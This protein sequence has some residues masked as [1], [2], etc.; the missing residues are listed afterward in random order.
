[1]KYNTPE[2]CG[3]PTEAIK[4]YIDHL[5]GK[6][7]S[8]HS[9]IICR[10]DD[11]VFEKYWAPFTRDFK[12]RMYSVTKSFVAFAIGF[13]LD[14]GR[15]SLDDP[16]SKYFPKECALVSDDRIKE[17]SIRNMLMMCTAYPKNGHFWFNTRTDDR[18]L[19]Y[20]TNNDGA[21]Y[22]AGTAYAYDSPGTFVLGSMV[23]RLTGRTL[24]DYLKEKMFDKI[25]VGDVDMLKCP[26]GHSWSDSALLMR[27]IDLAK[28]ARFTLSFGSHNGEQLISESFMRDAT[29]NLTSTT[30]YGELN[31]E[32]FG[33]GYYIW[34]TRNNSFFFNGMGC[35]LAVCN[36]KKDL[37][38]IYN[39]DNQGN[40]VAKSHIIDGFFDIVYP[41][42]QNDP[43]PEYRGEPIGEYSL[44]TP[45]G[46][47]TPAIAESIS[48]KRYVLDENPMGIS[49][50]TIT[51]SGDVG[52]FDY[53]N[54][55]GEKSIEFGFGKNIFAK[56]PEDGYSD[57][58]GSVSAPGNKYDSAS[59]A[60][61]LT[62][63]D[64]LIR[65]QIIDKYFGNLGMI[66]SFRDDI[67]TVHMQKCAEDF[68][69]TYEGFATGAIKN[70]SI[71][72]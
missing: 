59:S 39:G 62:E 13:L 55:T 31:V 37:I 50:F 35:Q 20:F 70:K 57:L 53:V 43:L 12:H 4:E 6:G 66:F 22:P 5:E 33:Y 23:E 32:K 16:I 45:K 27:P 29:S 1:M 9:V 30:A 44:F 54:K 60:A 36:E 38:L 52:R 68:L 28:C 25:G 17:Q 61:W 63:K 48:G 71:R 18:V 26:G 51:L 10:G 14:E 11:V 8:T 2:N 19:E 15:I 67:V 72:N 46:I 42:V 41:K 21:M 49:E 65:V 56:F 47:E 34:R 58:V 3:I 69:A 64:L 7:L 40:P 24:I